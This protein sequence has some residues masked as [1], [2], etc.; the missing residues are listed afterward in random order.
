MTYTILDLEP[1][2]SKEIA[3]LLAAEGDK[4]ALGTLRVIDVNITT[5]EG[6]C[7]NGLE[8]LY[9]RS[10]EPPVALILQIAGY[11]KRK[12]LIYNLNYG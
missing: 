11:I 5:E 4:M 3:K 2:T 1:E 9:A 12:E 10:L 7:I 6:I 8:F